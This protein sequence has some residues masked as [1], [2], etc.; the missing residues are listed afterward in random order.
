MS[1]C[2]LGCKGELDGVSLV[3]ARKKMEQKRICSKKE[4]KQVAEGN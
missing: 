4:K 1:I 3:S 2:I